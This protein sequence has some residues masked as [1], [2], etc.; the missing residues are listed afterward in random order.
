MN[1]INI[2][3]CPQFITRDTSLIREIMAPRNSAVQKQS[4]AEAVV[5]PGARTLAHFHPVTE[6]IYYILS[7]SGRMALELET[8]EVSCG[9]A[10]G[11]MPG[12]RHQI[13]NCGSEA[14]VFLCCC[15]PAY[16]HHDTVECASLL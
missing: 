12:Q 2:E 9:D 16:E 6:E 15:V 13:E 11:I 8:F 7:G 10:I 4:L 14:L 3:T 5:P 1:R